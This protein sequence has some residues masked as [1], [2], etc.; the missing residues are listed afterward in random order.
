MTHRQVHKEN[1]MEGGW[2]I[3]RF[4]NIRLKQS[5]NNISDQT[6]SSAYS[7]IK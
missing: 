1:S 7:Q 2:K 4:G 5:V 3:K 6:I